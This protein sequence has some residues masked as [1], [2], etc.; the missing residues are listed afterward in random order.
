MLVS[1]R[2]TAT[3]EDILRVVATLQNRGIQSHVVREAS[4]IVVA[5]EDGSYVRRAE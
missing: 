1:M 4:R 2:N 3:R 5:T